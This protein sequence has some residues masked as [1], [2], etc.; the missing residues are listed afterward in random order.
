MESVCRER[1]KMQNRA[2]ETFKKMLA[3]SLGQHRPQCLKS[4]LET[5]SN[6]QWI[7]IFLSIITD[8][9]LCLIFQ[10][11]RNR[12]RTDDYSDASY[13]DDHSSEEDENKDLYEDFTKEKAAAHYWECLDKIQQLK[14]WMYLSTKD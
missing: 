6:S 7:K 1:M 2:N 11:L 4:L 8:E 12:N 9:Q 3:R 13:F 14:V 10:E 5:L